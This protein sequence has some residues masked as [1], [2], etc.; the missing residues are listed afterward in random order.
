MSINDARKQSLYFPEEMLVE[1]EP[2]AQ[3]LDR[4]LSWVVQ[5]LRLGRYE[6]ERRCEPRP[7]A[8]IPFCSTARPRQAVN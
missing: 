4:S 7:Q 2:Q 6:T 3:R 8:S 1:I 5:P